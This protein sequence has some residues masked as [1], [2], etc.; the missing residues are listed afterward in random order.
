MDKILKMRQA[1]VLFNRTAT[2]NGE[3]ENDMQNPKD[4]IQ[5]LLEK[6]EEY[7][8]TRKDLLKLKLVSKASDAISSVI[9]KVITIVF[10]LF[11]F[12]I[13]NIGLSILIG[14]WLGKVY[15]GFFVVAG[16]YLIVGIIINSSGEKLIK[17]SV[18]NNL[19][20]KFIK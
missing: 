7:I 11:F 5:H 9:A 12:V 2:G 18:A 16:F 6:A 3:K 20:K 13:L 19:I 15:L 14:E 8:K 17:R 1:G 4:E 10:F